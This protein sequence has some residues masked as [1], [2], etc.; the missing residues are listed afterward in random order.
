MANNTSLVPYTPPTQTP[1]V[2]YQKQSTDL[3]PWI[4]LGGVAIGGFALYEMLHGA[5][6]KYQ[7]IDSATSTIA[8]SGT[9]T[10]DW[11]P[12]IDSET[13]TIAH[14]GTTTPDWTPAID[15]ETSTITYL[16]IGTNPTITLADNT[17]APGQSI[18]WSLSGFPGNLVVSMTVNEYSIN[19]TTDTNGNYGPDNFPATENLTPGNYQL[20]ASWFNNLTGVSVTF[21]VAVPVTINVTDDGSGLGFTSVTNASGVNINGESVPSGTIITITAYVNNPAVAEFTDWTG[22]APFFNGTLPTATFAATDNVNLIA[23]FQSLTPPPP[24]PPTKPVFPAPGI[25][26]DGDT[27]YWVEFMDSTFGWQDFNEVYGSTPNNQINFSDPIQG[28]YA[29]GATS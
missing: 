13:S 6:G 22:S 11:T 26:G 28:P 9:A 7:L 29:S 20:N 12:A 10:P 8:H 14:S 25:V 17:I 2:Y 21:T 18:E 4:I 15:S 27:W 23:H 3:I 16:A 1:Q 5:S 24:P 19:V